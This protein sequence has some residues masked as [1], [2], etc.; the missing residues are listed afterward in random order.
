MTK[1]SISALCALLTLT[2]APAARAQLLDPSPDPN[3]PPS[4]AT[5]QPP[6]SAPTPAATV[7]SPV[8]QAQGSEAPEAASAAPEATRPAPDSRRAPAAPPPD[9]RPGAS[10]APIDDEHAYVVESEAGPV[11][12]KRSLPTE[13]GRWGWSIYGNH[14]VGIPSAADSDMSIS[15]VGVRRWVSPKFGWEAATGLVINSPPGEGAET[16]A[17]LGVQGALLYSLARY[18]YLNIFAAGRGLLVPYSHP[19]PGVGMFQFGLSGEV[20]AELFLDGLQLFHAGPLLRTSRALSV[21]VGFGLGMKVSHVFVEGGDGATEFNLGTTK[22][23]DLVNG[24]TTGTLAITYY[25]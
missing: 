23:D 4:P 10:P 18:E 6:T 19:A 9:G 1:P 17:A 16:T 2:M 14:G 5:P 22:A 13:V 8:P 21:T 25:F 3:P 24:F 12:I 20:A 11:T 15:M 7:G